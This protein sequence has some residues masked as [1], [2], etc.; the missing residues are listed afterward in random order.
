MDGSFFTT[1]D[2]AQN[3][4]AGRP[5]F[6]DSFAGGGGASAGIEMA[7]GRSPDYA[8][9]HDARALA[10]HA[11]NHPDTL[12]LS[13]NIWRVDPLDVVA[14][15][16]VDLAWFS[17]D[18]KHFSRAKGSVPVSKNIRDLAWVVPNWGKRARPRMIFVENVEEFLTWGPLL[19]SG[20][21]DP[22][23]KGE[24]F[25]EWVRALKAL[26]Y[27]VDW[28]VSRACDHGAPTI[29]KRL[30][31]IARRDGL[32]I[33]WPRPTHGKPGDP[34]VVAGDLKPW[35]TAAEIIDWSVPCPSIFDTS[36]EI[37]EKHG[38]RARRPLAEN[39]LKRIAAGVQRYVIDAAE[40]FFVTYGQQGG[41]NRSAGDPVH[42][43][44][45]SR[46]DCNAI[47]VPTLVQT[48]YGE[49]AGQAPRVPGLDK[50]LGTIVAGAGKHALVAAFLAQHNLARGGVHAGRDA[51]AP[52]STVTSTGSQQGLVACH[53]INQKGSAQASHDPC[54]PLPT[55]CAATVHAGVVAAF[56]TKYYGTGDGAV[57]GSP[58]PTVTVRDRFGLVTVNVEGEDYA[59]VDI[60]LRMLTPRE[61]F[62]AQGFPEDYVIDRDAS[63]RAF[64]KY[65]QVAKAGNSVSPPWAAAHIRA[66]WGGA[67]A[68][69]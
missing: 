30:L 10:M 5:L 11:V 50:P 4:V 63:G 23:R 17:P 8:I 38:I 54:H 6:V 43:I 47:V 56:L 21:P 12:H 68:A 26:G 59:I 19:A 14:G 51:R 20:K 45:A 39:T 62:R 48:G 31:V 46:K 28:R 66:N 1:A 64:T 49:R 60:G 57:I 29:R 15:R 16:P 44:T 9:N 24:T 58:A 27:S 33:V 35:R 2:L 52:V 53:L 3:V 67:G 42:T 13:E 34:R 36:E 22:A 69:P 18:C 25:N 61:L 40:P 37:M 55:I 41:A 7:T 32:P 65:D